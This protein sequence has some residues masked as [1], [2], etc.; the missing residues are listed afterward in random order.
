MGAQ[1]MHTRIS[2]QIKSIVQGKTSCIL[3]VATASR[4]FLKTVKYVT[5]IVVK[6]QNRLKFVQTVHFT[7]MYNSIRHHINVKN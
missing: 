4:H 3:P 7:M 5:Q 6:I 1:T 2:K